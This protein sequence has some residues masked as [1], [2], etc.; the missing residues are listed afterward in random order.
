MSKNVMTGLFA[1]ALGGIYLIATLN[2]RQQTMG[3]PTGPKVFPLIVASLLILLGIL[4]LVKEIRTPKE[5]RSIL[6][7]QLTPEGKKV[8]IRIVVTSI[9]GIIYGF[10]LDPLG[11]LISTAV[12]MLGLMFLVNTFARWKQNIMV[13]IGFSLVTYIG[14]ATLLHLSLPRGIFSF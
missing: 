9:A 7:F 5:L 1:V 4:L 14:F 2:L 3:D 13:S 10:L 6:S 11:Y 8:L 12:F